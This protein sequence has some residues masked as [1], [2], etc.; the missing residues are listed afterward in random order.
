M[1]H[2]LK[3]ER[4]IALFLVLWVMALLTVIA[5]EFCYAIR[6]EVTITRN[7]KEETQTYY[8]AESG[9]FWAIGELVVNDFVPREV[10]AP[11]GKEEPEDI[12]WGINTDI[13]AIPFGEGQFKVERENESGKVNLNRA[14]G[15]L[16][17]MILNNFEIEDTDKNI[18]VDSIMD[19]R[20]KDNFHRA[21]GAEDDY[22][23]A[24]PEPYKCKNG[25]FTSIDEL[26][27][28]R[29]V[30]PQL[31]HGGLKDM[32]SIYHD[33]DTDSAI[34]IH[35][36]QQD[37][38]RETA[39]RLRV[40]FAFNRININAASPRMLRVLPRMT[41]DVVQK[42]MKYRG[43]KDFRSLSDLQRVVGTEVYAAISPYITLTLSPYYTIKSVGMLK[44]SQTRQGVQAVVKIDRTLNK[45][46]EIIQWIDGLEYRS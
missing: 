3:S 21:N 6:T 33:K 39:R 10:K 20:D 1:K 42:I 44:E 15:S 14:D 23:L 36:D 12:R 26:L 24:L 2:N 29:G 40:Y 38:E 30:T 27:L 8:I 16:L 41:E 17:K 43:K 5:G 34:T 37:Q 31:F 25:D 4:G 19:W 32:V 28:V 7:F 18:I 11:A 22:Y 35:Q 9:L 46:Y 13:P 45:G